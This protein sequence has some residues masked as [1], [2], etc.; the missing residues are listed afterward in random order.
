MHYEICLYKKATQTTQSEFSTS[1]TAA[2]TCC[3]V[4]LIYCPS[5]APTVL[6]PVTQIMRKSIMVPLS[7]G[8]VTLINAERENVLA[9][10]DPPTAKRTP[11]V[12]IPRYVIDSTATQL[13]KRRHAALVILNETMTTIRSGNLFPREKRPTKYINGRNSEKT[14]AV[15][16]EA[17][18]NGQFQ[19]SI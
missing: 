13:N 17:V 11:V 5:N 16:S 2:K 1:R 14:P 9:V 15:Y 12:N 7:R 18:C 4:I 19:L 10:F 3:K 6:P 8:G